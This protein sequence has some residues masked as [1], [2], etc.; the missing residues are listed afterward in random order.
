MDEYKVGEGMNDQHLFQ[1]M[2]QEQFSKL[3]YKERLEV[4]QK[5]P[6]SYQKLSEACKPHRQFLVK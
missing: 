3:G 1:N 6:E 5:D 4:K 2:T